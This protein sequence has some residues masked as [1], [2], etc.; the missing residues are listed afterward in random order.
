[1]GVTLKGLR[2][3]YDFYHQF[4]LRGEETARGNFKEFQTVLIKHNKYLIREEAVI[5]S[6]YDN[7]NCLERDASLG[8]PIVSIDRG[9]AL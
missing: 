2:V 9:H 5:Y 7:I 6:K 8:K 4:S 3:L 1:M